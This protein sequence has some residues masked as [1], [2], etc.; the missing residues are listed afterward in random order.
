MVFALDGTELPS[1]VISLFALIENT[2]SYRIS[3][4]Y[5]SITLAYARITSLEKSG[6]KS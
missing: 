3:Q 1:L 6:F 2:T 4:L 5:F